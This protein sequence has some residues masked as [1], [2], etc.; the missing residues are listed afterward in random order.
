MSLLSSYGKH[1]WITENK[2]ITIVNEN[3]HKD[4]VCVIGIY[5]NIGFTLSLKKINKR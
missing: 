2:V 5:D 4:L 1:I 3:L